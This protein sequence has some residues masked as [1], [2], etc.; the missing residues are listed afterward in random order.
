MWWHDKES[1]WWPRGTSLLH[2]LEFLT[3]R[4]I[5]GTLTKNSPCN[6]TRFFYYCPVWLK[7][8]P[9][10]PLGF[11]C[12]FFGICIYGLVLVFC[13]YKFLTKDIKVLSV[14]IAENVALWTL[15]KKKKRRRKYD[16]NTLSGKHVFDLHSAWKDILRWNLS[17]KRLIRSSLA[18]LLWEAFHCICLVLNPYTDLYIPSHLSSGTGS[19]MYF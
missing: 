19:C 9:L 13:A 18:T 2:E 16:C 12:S 10:I 17:Y 4:E 11:F 8:L 6:S 14:K 15:R 3:A 1:D 7:L 5:Q